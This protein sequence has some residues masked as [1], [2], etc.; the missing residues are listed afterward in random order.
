MDPLLIMFIFVALT[1]EVLVLYAA[2][3]KGRRR[4]ELRRIAVDRF[5]R[6]AEQR[7]GAISKANDEARKKIEELTVKLS[8]LKLEAG[9]F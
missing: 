1:L 7:A 6:Q 2:Y 3:D 8:G 5:C 9:G 4:L